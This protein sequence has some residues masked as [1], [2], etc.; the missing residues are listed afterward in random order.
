MRRFLRVLILGSV[1]VVVVPLVLLIS[2]L[3]DDDNPWDEATLMLRE[4]LRPDV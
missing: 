3:M 1:A 2:W 4:V